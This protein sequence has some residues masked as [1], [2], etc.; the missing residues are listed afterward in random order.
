VAHEEKLVP[1]VGLGIM[2]CGLKWRHGENQPTVAGIN[3]GELEHIAK[4]GPVGFGILG[5]DNH[6]RS[7][8]QA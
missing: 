7:I 3:A 8:D 4:K 6:M 1:V 5:I 2:E